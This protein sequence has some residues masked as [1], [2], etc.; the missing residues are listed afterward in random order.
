MEQNSDRIFDL[1]TKLTELTYLKDQERITFSEQEEK[2]K[3]QL[4]ELLKK[5]RNL[6]LQSRNYEDD[7]EARENEKSRFRNRMQNEE[8]ERHNLNM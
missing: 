8:T 5:Y 3:I 4:E 7:V 2:Q 1:D 6:A